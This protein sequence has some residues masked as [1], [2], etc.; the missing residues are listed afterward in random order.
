MKDRLRMIRT[1]N[2]S[3]YKVGGAVGT[4]ALPPSTKDTN[5]R[6]DPVDGEGV[7][8]VEGCSYIKDTVLSKHRTEK[9]ASVAIQRTDL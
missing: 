4:E 5:G 6:T 9:I 8:S 3:R 2:K 1:P 7:A